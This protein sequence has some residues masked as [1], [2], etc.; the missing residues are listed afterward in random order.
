MSHEL[1]TML[2]PA[3]QLRKPS[4]RE[5][6]SWLGLAPA[7]CLIFLLACA[8]LTGVL[9]T[10]ASAPVPQPA[11]RAAYTQLIPDGKGMPVQLRLTANKESFTLVQA[12][13][14]FALLDEPVELDQYAARELMATGAAV[15]SRQTLTGDA[16]DFGLNTPSV[17][18]VYTYADGSIITLTLGN[19][20]ATGE[21]WYA[22]VD[23]SGEV[24]IVNNSLQR[25][26]A[27]GRHVLYALP[28]LSQRFAAGT[29][30][31]ATIACPGQDAVT[32]ARVT[33]ENPFNTMAELTAP[34]HYPAN[35][36]RAAEIYLALE[37]IKPVGVLAAEGEDAD[38][39]LDAPIAVIRL[40]DKQLTTLT[41]GMKDDTCT[42]RIDED[43][44]VY[45]LDSSTLTFLQH[46]TVPYL[47]EQLPGLIALNKVTVLEV[48]AGEESFAFTMDPANAAYTLQGKT[49]D[50]ETFIGLY[51]QLIGVLVERYVP[52]GDAVARPRVTFCY[53]LVDGSQWT[54]AFAPYDEQF[55]LI[56]RDG[57]ANFLISRSKV[58]AVVDMLRRQSEK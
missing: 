33:Q 55:D 52:D 36:E 15:I 32:I 11:Q 46:V 53:T 7:I 41:I 17:Q 10:D 22:A 20:V 49:L 47:A 19:A 5:R 26:L 34:I 45:A 31:E 37:A 48:T 13:E 1:H 6:A 28:D 42:L 12:G 43:K 44:A 30:L 39:G 9:E 14:K 57:C 35:S 56:I 50:A 18:A 2:E 4:R 3:A 25:T 29:L 16:A 40:K 21:G 24:Y 54:L 51:Q 38:W 58:D 27:M 8:A 23:G